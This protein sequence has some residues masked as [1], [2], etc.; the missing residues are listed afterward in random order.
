MLTPVA[1]VAEM[2]IA[3]STRLVELLETAK[4]VRIVR[5]EMGGIEGHEKV[6][7]F[8]ELDHFL[9]FVQDVGIEAD[10]V[11][12]VGH[13]LNGDD[14]ATA[15]DQALKIF[16]FSEPPPESKF[17]GNHRGGWKLTRGMSNSP[18]IS[19]IFSSV[20]IWFPQPAILKKGA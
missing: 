18:A 12:D 5:A 14:G 7:F 20:F 6:V 10:P 11:A 19:I 16:H 8:N 4:K 13:I 3:D 1:V 15:F 17:R 2:N 9:C